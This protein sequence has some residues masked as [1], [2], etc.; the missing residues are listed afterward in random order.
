MLIL[1]LMAGLALCLMIAYI[2]IRIVA[3][4]LLDPKKLFAGGGGEGGKAE[5]EALL[6]A[7]A[8]WSMNYIMKLW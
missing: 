1:C 8:T 2:V 6:S 4:D 7:A 3:P 5:A